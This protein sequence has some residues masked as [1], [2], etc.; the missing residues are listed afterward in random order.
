MVEEAYASQ[1]ASMRGLQREGVEE[2]PHRRPAVVGVLTQN[3]VPHQRC[4]VPCQPRVGVSICVYVCASK[5]R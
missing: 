5:A 1:G 4:H 2:V 3:P